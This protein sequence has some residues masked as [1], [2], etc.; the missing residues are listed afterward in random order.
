[1]FHID[2]DTD[3]MVT[4]YEKK[5]DLWKINTKKN[6]DKSR[7]PDLETINTRLDEIEKN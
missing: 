4:S 6:S 1:M 7:K 2:K 3:L 5:D